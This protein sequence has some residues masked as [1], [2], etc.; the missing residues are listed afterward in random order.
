MEIKVIVGDI[1]GMEADAIIVNHFEG[2]KSPEGETAAVD[3][4]LDGAISQLVKQGEIKGKPNE[5]TMLHSFGKLPAARVVIVGLGK[6]PE[7]SVNKVRVAVAEA[8]RWLRAREI[9]TVATVPQGAGLNNIIPAA[10]AQAAAEGH[11]REAV[12][13]L[14]AR[15]Q[16]GHQGHP[17]SAV[18]VVVGPGYGQPEAGQIGCHVAVA[19]AVHERAEGAHQAARAAAA[20]PRSR[21]MS[22]RLP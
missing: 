19:G 7:L 16:V 12:A 5:I 8:C 17:R 20:S 6:Q 18:G 13:R 1:A 22:A 14:L 21:A 15:D 4:A 2:V 11:H 9:S 10:A 3:R